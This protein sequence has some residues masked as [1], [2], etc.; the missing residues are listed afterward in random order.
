MY[1][2]KD[3]TSVPQSST[4]NTVLERRQCWLHERVNF[5]KMAKA[6][7]SKAHLSAKMYDQNIIACA[8][9]NSFFSLIRVVL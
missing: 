4:K 7:V 6:S 1:N 2:P 5:N 3:G 8:V 9:L